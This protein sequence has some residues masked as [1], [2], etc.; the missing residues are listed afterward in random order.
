MLSYLLN[1]RRLFKFWYYICLLLRKIIQF[2]CSRKRY[3]LFI[4]MILVILSTMIW[5]QNQSTPIEQR[6]VKVE[7]YA[8]K[9]LPE[10]ALKEVEAI[11]AQAKKEKN[12]VEVIKAMVYKMRFTL[13]KNLEEA[14]GLIRDF[15][16]FTDKSTDPAEKALLHSMTAE[17]YTQFYQKDSRSINNRTE[18]VAYVP[19]DMK[20]WTKN[21]F[22]DKI[23]KH[24]AAS[25][26][27]PAV[28]QHTDALKFAGLMHTG[29]DSK[30]LQPTL[31]DFLG[32]RKIEILQEISQ[33]TNFLRISQ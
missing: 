33:A 16:A 12:S 15:E 3:I 30:I 22:F 1:G 4:P 25:M 26:E 14:P 24:L 8:E 18:L 21:I 27:H 5:A 23:S 31:F 13:D 19:E 7:E 32:Y 17:L 11:L 28:L 10:S 20:E 29:M 2:L 9:Q 6:W